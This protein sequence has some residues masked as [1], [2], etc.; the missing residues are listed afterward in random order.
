MNLINEKI[1]RQGRE[2]S[3]IRDVHVEDWEI[4]DDRGGETR[5][6][7]RNP[8]A[9]RES[10]RAKKGHRGVLAS[11]DNMR[12]LGIKVLMQV[13]IRFVVTELGHWAG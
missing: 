5:T 12:W 4:E 10:M 11:L 1:A 9:T 6:G 8:S 2:T 7:A 13:I 3:R